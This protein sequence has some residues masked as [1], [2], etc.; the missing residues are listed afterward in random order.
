MSFA[1]GANEHP[2][3]EER[4]G[5]LPRYTIRTY[6]VPAKVFHW[7]TAGLVF[8]MVASGVT[9]KQLGEGSI[10]D[11]LFNIHKTTGV[12]TL[13]V[14][15]LRLIYRVAMPDPGADR[16][17]YRRPFL[18]WMLYAAL[19][20]MPLLGWSGISDF[21]SRGILFGLELPAI[22]PEGSGYAEFL[23]ET[24]A[25]LAFGMLALVALH[26]GIAMQDHMTRARD[27]GESDER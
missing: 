22:W 14:V 11:T 17:D 15:L 19:I 16:E 18:H 7:V 23:L 20:L 12:L 27:A 2:V 10:A 9:M 26:V 6:R 8:F 24:H 13:A 21:G 25:Y 1:A 5:S 3:R 4:S